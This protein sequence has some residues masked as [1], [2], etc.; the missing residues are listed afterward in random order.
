MC[1]RGQ[2]GSSVPVRRRN[3]MLL[4]LGQEKDGWKIEVISSDTIL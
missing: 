2:F 3:T 1:Y 4:L